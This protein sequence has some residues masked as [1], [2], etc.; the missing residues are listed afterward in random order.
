MPDALLDLLPLRVRTARACERDPDDR[1]VVL[2]PRYGGW[3]GRI[4]QPR[5]RRPFFRLRLDAV[6]TFV[7]DRCDGERSG[8]AIACELAAAFPELQDPRA[9]VALFLRQLAVQGHVEFGR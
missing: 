7:W 8:E 2:V 5:L 6:G 9:R 3:I 1:V 4:L